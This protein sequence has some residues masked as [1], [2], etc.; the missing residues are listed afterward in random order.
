M[1]GCVRKIVEQCLNSDVGI[2]QM[3]CPEQPAWGGI[4][5]RLFITGKY[6]QGA[7]NIRSVLDCMYTPI[8]AKN[9]MSARMILR[10]TPWH[11]RDH[12]QQVERLSAEG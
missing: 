6:L 2:V 9:H 10:R 1:G 8:P 7:E 5:K 4:S 12:T 3:P 11:E